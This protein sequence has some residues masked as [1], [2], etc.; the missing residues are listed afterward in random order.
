MQNNEMMQNLK[1]LVQEIGIFTSSQRGFDLQDFAGWLS[2]RQSIRGL[3][4]RDVYYICLNRLPEKAS[5]AAQGYESPAACA[6]HILVCMQSEEFR[7]RLPELMFAALPELKRHFFV[8]I[9]RTGGTSLKRFTEVNLALLAW[10]E[11]Y[12]ENDWFAWQDKSGYPGG[13]RYMLRFL[14]QFGRSNPPPFYYTGHFSLQG[15][16]GRGLVRPYDEL[17][18]VVRNPTE[19]VI[20]TVNYIF[21]VAHSDLRSP[22]AIDWISWIQSIEP[23]WVPD[24][25]V[26]SQLI[27]RFLRSD[28]FL[29]EYGDLMTRYLSLDQTVQGAVDSV[30]ISKCR[31]IWLDEIGDYT[32]DVLGVVQP[33][34]RDNASLNIV[35]DTGGLSP[36]LLD[37]VDTVLCGRDHALIASL[38]QAGLLSPSSP[39][40]KPQRQL[41]ATA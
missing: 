28:R 13:L 36:D 20:S 10:N 11:S 8:H 3:T 14:G 31:L 37:Y 22:D 2:G 6:A 34:V 1:D 27:D 23:D 15:L 4:V 30:I 17:V 35:R 29:E 7:R 5:V 16:L 38:L 25:E 26:T 41:V 33:V 40:V 18:A 12:I 39:S 9:P 21:M 32:R 24:A 19:I